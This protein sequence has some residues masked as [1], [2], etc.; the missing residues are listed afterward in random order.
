[1]IKSAIVNNEFLD[2]VKKSKLVVIRKREN[3]F[4]DSG[5][6]QGKAVNM[7]FQCMSLDPEI[8]GIRFSVKTK[9]TD[10]KVGD[11]VKANVE[12]ANVYALT[13]RDVPRNTMIP[14]RISLRGQ[15]TKVVDNQ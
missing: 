8:S 9:I 14:I 2:H 11:I 13:T 7:V 5:N 3:F 10:V 12:K 6:K 4:D 1:M 15:L